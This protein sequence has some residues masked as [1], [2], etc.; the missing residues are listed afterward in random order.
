VKVGKVHRRYLDRAH[1]IIALLDAA[2]AMDREARSDRRALSRRAL[3]AT[4]VFAGLRISE[5]LDLRW[6]DVDL[7][8]G[9]LRLRAS[10][11]T[12]VC[13]TCRCWRCCATS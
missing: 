12:P 1:Q 3:I 13:A 2:G 10:R 9:R 6:R 7:A 11:P 5:A 8:G 4:L